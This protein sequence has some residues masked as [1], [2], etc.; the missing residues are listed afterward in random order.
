M[1][2]STSTCS[3]PYC[4]APAIPYFVDTDLC[5][6]HWVPFLLARGYVY[7]EAEASSGTRRRRAQ[8][9]EPPAPCVEEEEDWSRFDDEER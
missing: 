4:K 5:A 2:P 7:T 9:I 1:A 3:H 6:E 8:V